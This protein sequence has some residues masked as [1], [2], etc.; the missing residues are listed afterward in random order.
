[1]RRTTAKPGPGLGTGRTASR[2][3]VGPSEEW[4]ETDSVPDPQSPDPFLSFGVPTPV[5]LLPIKR[6]VRTRGFGLEVEKRLLS[7]P[8]RFRPKEYVQT[9]DGTFWFFCL[10]KRF[11]H[12]RDT[13][14]SHPQRKTLSSDPG[15]TRFSGTGR[16][17]RH[18]PLL[19]RPSGTTVGR[20]TT[21]RGDLES[22]TTHEGLSLQQ[23]RRTS[24]GLR[25]MSP[26]P[27]LYG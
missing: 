10:L 14:L 17:G 7:P 13:L 18:A 4:T 23:T 26:R 8:F 2:Q 16:R 25:P 1:M 9:K 19:T 22:L 3:T 11:V 5:L 12:I 27:V 24:K 6:R 21:P 15:V 20:T